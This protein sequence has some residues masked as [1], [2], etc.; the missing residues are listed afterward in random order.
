[1]TLRF[2][3]IFLAL[4]LLPACG[5][6]VGG[7]CSGAADCNAIAMGCAPECAPDVGGGGVCVCAGPA[8][9]EASSALIANGSACAN[10]PACAS[11]LCLS[12]VCAASWATPTTCTI[13]V[14]TSH[15]DLS[16]VTATTTGQGVQI[17]RPPV[18][19]TQ[20]QVGFIFVHGGAYV[21]PAW[22]LGGTLPGV[23]RAAAFPLATL[24]YTTFAVQYRY[25]PGTVSPG[26]LSDVRC[27]IAWVM[28]HA[29]AY[30]V[31]TDG[32]GALRLVLM[33]DSVGAQLSLRAI[34]GT[35]AD[36]DG[37][38][39]TAPGAL[40]VSSVFAESGLYNIGDTGGAVPTVA[41]NLLGRAYNAG[42]DSGLSPL[43]A[44][45]AGAPPMLSTSITG[46]VL[47]P[48]A[49][50]GAMA[51]GA[52]AVGVVDTTVG[53]TISGCSGWQCHDPSVFAY[54]AIGCPLLAMLAGQ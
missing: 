46:D 7:D 16:V 18:G 24:G 22:T 40:A 41:H 37:T 53:V 38:C 3:P 50:M 44:I 35:S 27:G 19:T 33:G 48:Y 23:T 6:G 9:G 43:N 39:D 52:G 49:Q 17:V 36:D 4:L 21:G 31:G 47:V 12:G 26:N 32:A 10:N 13:P 14:A 2:L 11:G 54:P 5:N 45:A 42:T 15:Q 30:G 1:M 8:L 29:A 51:A 25:A 28:A 34:E 20:Q